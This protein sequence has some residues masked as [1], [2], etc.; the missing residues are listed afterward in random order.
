MTLAEFCERA[1]SVPYLD[2]GRSWSGWDCWG[3]VYVA[4]RDVLGIDL[5]SWSD[6]YVTAADRA[7]IERLIH[8]G[9]SDWTEIPLPEA[10][11]GDV[12]LL[13][14]GGR[15]SHVGLIVGPRILHSRE[16]VGTV[17]EPITRWRPRL[18]GL[19]RHRH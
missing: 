3:L 2:K 10:R 8:D 16:R 1:I 18:V 9:R 7:E 11:D 4:Y 12:A 15:D 17:L 19:Y 6:A 5:P 14:D 13:R